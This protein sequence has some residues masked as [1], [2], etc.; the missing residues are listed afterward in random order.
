MA[1]FELL[2]LLVR[3]DLAQCMIKFACHVIYIEN[4]NLS[5]Y[6]DF[7]LY[8]FRNPVYRCMLKPWR[9]ILQWTLYFVTLC[10]IG[11]DLSFS[12]LRAMFPQNFSPCLLLYLLMLIILNFFFSLF[13]QSTY[14]RTDSDGD[15]QFIS[16]LS[17]PRPSCDTSDE[18]VVPTH[19][20]YSTFA[21]PTYVL[22]CS[23]LYL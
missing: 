18:G 1:S 19:K 23:P 9:I 20:R 3:F 14:T 7:S 8:K 17:T 10:N 11:F 21:G 12:L 5:A 22:A 4:Y 13:G 6:A 15:Q 2:L 16:A